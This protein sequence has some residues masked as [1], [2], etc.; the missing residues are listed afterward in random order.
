MVIECIELKDI[1]SGRNYLNL[2]GE[3][4]P[5]V[6]LRELFEIVG[7]P[8]MRQN[9]VIVQYAGRKAGLVV[10][11]LHGALQ[12]VIKPLAATFKHLRGIAGSTILGS[13]EVAL[14]L[15]VQVLIDLAAQRDTEAQSEVA[16]GAASLGRADSARFLQ[17]HYQQQR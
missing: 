3:V 5:F 9:V 16:L 15:D 8:P 6:R 14:I 13:G 4:L 2:R 7:T 11:A 12:T 10:D 17:S 1:P